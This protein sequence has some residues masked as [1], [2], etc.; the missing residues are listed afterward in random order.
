MVK[1]VVIIG[2]IL[3][4][5]LDIP[6][7]ASGDQPSGNKDQQT[8][9]LELPINHF[10]EKKVSLFV[11]VPKDFRPLQSMNEARRM[12]EF[13]LQGDDEWK[14]SRIIT[15]NVEIGSETSAVIYRDT[16]KSMFQSQAESCEFLEEEIKAYEDY[17]SATLAMSYT[18]K[19]RKEVIYMRL[20]SGPADL[21]AIQ[22]AKALAK[23]E[24]PQQ[25]LTELKAFVSTIA[26]VGEGAKVSGK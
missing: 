10:I 13:I 26:Q 11:K 6:G 20:Y 2:V 5:F 23:G 16:F 3:W 17:E 15:L 21:C 19:G 14:W 18:T 25:A 9:T 12:L 7:Y 1:F 8:V 24:T 22:Y 4:G